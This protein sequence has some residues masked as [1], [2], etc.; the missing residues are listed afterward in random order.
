MR[1][2]Q[3]CCHRKTSR[4]VSGSGPFTAD[5]ACGVNTKADQGSRDSEQARS[6]GIEEDVAE[7]PRGAS[8]GREVR[9]HS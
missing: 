2:K 4:I 7:A 5:F 3:S 6:G 1:N 8:G 9:S